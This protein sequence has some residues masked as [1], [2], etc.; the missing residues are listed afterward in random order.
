MGRS[1]HPCLVKPQT[2][3]MP[4]LCVRASVG[5]VNNEARTIDLIFSTGAAVDRMDPWT[6][7][8][9]REVLSMDPAHIRLDRLNAG[10][11]LL[12]THSGYSIADVLGAVQ[13]GSARVEKGSGHRDGAL[14]QA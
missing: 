4:A 3:D 8:R 13:P 6:G 12:D 5:T 2:V 9:Y 10:A 1:P 7:K 11:P 14:Q